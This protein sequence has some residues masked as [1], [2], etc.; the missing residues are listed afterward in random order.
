MEDETKATVSGGLKYLCLCSDCRAPK[1]SVSYVELTM[2]AV[3]LARTRAGHGT[4]HAV[5][6]GVGLMEQKGVAPL[7][8]GLCMS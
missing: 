2:C 4:A 3:M 7:A 5:K 6:G 8:P 1:M